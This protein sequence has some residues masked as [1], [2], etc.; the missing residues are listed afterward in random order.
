M[1]KSGPANTIVLPH[2]QGHDGGDVFNKSGNA[3]NH[4]PSRTI[5]LGRTIDLVGKSCIIT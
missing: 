3:E 2:L 1:S 4:I 5:L